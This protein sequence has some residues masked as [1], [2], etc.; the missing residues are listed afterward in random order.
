[1][2]IDCSLYIYVYVYLFIIYLYT[3]LFIYLFILVRKTH[4]ER[5]RAR[6][7]LSSFCLKL[8]AAYIKSKSD[9]KQH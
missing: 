9:G 1:M 8:I 3:Y 4:Q 7:S 5:F 2:P 6:P